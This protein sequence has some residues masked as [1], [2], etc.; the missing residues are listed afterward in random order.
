ESAPNPEEMRKIK[1]Q[2]YTDKFANPF[3]AAA[4]GYID[5]VI[6]PEETREQILHCLS[7]GKNKKV[8]NLEKKHGIP[9]F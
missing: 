9:P 3:K 5:G 4:N 2:E 6:V 8:Q 7:I 1:V